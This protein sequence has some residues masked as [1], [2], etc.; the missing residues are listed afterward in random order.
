MDEVWKAGARTSD[1]TG[2]GRTLVT[3]ATGSG[4]WLLAAPDAV[5]PATVGPI[6]SPTA[7]AAIS[8]ATGCW[9]ILSPGS[10]GTG[11]APTSAMTSATVEAVNDAQHAQAPAARMIW[12]NC[13]LSRPFST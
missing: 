12:A 8:A 13:P 5:A 6:V 11:R 9:K 4:G 2:T 10:I 3:V 7:T 1:V